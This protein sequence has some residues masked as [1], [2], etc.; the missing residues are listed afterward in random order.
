MKQPA[1]WK[2]LFAMTLLLIPLVFVASLAVGPQQVARGKSAST[3]LADE[4]GPTQQAAQELA[5]Q[6][7]RVQAL[8]VGHRSEVMGVVPVGDQ[9]TEAS[10]ACASAACQQVN[11][12]NLDEN[13]SVVAIVDVAAGQ[14]LDVLH[15]A[16]MRPGINKRL[17]DRAREIAFNAPELI[18]VLGYQ[19]TS[20]DWEPMDADLMNSVCDGDHFCVAPTFKVG[21]YILWAFVDLTT[22]Q[23]VDLA[24]SA[25]GD[26]SQATSQYFTPEGCP[27]SGTVSRD[28]WALNYETTPS[29]GFRVYNASYEG[30]IALNN[31]KLVEWHAD[32]GSSGYRDSTGC[33]GGG[34][35]G[36]PIY[37]YGQTQQQ[38]LLDGSDVIGFEL[39]QDFR[40]GSW[41]NSCNYRYEQ[42]YQFFND[43]RFR[44][45]AGAFGKGCGTNSLYRPLLMIDVAVDG[46]E[47]DSAARWD[48]SAWLPLDTELRMDPDNAV[49][50]EGYGWMVTDESGAGYYVEPGRG[51]FGD[52][53]LGDNEFVYIVQHQPIFNTDMGTIGDC[54][55]D[56]DHGPEE[57]VDGQS[58]ANQN[59][60]I[61]YVAQNQTNASAPNYYCWTVRGE[62]NPDTYPCFMGPMFTPIAEVV[63]PTASF[64]HNGPVALGEMA[65][66]DSTATG[67]EPLS[68]LWDFGDGESST[69][70]DPSHL[71]ASA[72]SYEVTLT[73][74]NEAGSAVAS[75]TFIVESPTALI[76]TGGL[77]LESGSQSGPLWALALSAGALATGLYL[78]RKRE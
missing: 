25:A 72:G 57:Y 44:V 68:Y 70:P 63:A 43:G 54:C 74:S 64:T 30:T 52:R 17:A 37:P 41:G 59:L 8:T 50:P 13:A 71:Y 20:S 29:D 58:I 2:W 5:L 26:D 65:T 46:D 76:T 42:H 24:W 28:G 15:Q 55:N 4:L 16:G 21:D 6:D 61:W 66:F 51:Q 7:A 73:V 45:V 77:S 11:I 48:G 62:P 56:F 60:V 47:G 75:G 31:A 69:E 40:M 39:V 23:F 49:S 32:Y 78:R 14:V 38:D 36:F 3:P 9:F 18:E 19:P 34:G 33:G 35:G 53:G 12:F 10:R 22:E 27:A 1:R 67:S